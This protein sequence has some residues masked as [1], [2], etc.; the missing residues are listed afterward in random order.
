[1]SDNSQSA[2]EGYVSWAVDVLFQLINIS[3]FLR[4]L[5]NSY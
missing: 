2:L 3:R 4:W 5:V 1:M